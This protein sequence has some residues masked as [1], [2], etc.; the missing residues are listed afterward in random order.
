MATLKC[1]VCGNE[2]YA[3]PSDVESGRKKYCSKLCMYKAFRTVPIEKI[4]PVCNKRFQVCPQGENSRFYP[5]FHKI[6]CST[7]CANKGR[8]RRG[9]KCNQLKDIDAAYI[10]GFLDADGSVMFY[11]RKKKTFL[12]VQFT[13][14]SHR[15]LAWI[16]GKISVGNIVSV[17]RYSKNH[18]PCWQIFVNS[19][20]ASTL[21]EQVAPYMITKNKQAKLALEYTEQKKNPE[22]WADIEWHLKIKASM[23]ALNK[24]GT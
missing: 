20:A 13:N 10:A 6:Y 8:Y 5:P 22:Y 12:R 11:T 14:R 1:I 16:R 17:K 23:Q 3:R 21:L 24:R 9:S 2:F 15:T 7:E 4:C 19:D 18:Q